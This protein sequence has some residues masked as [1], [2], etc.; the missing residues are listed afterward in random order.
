MKKKKDRRRL[1]YKSGANFERKVM[2]YYQDQGM[3]A[4]RSAGSHSPI[5]VVVINNKTKSVM[6]IQCKKKRMKLGN[7]FAEK[8]K[9]TKEALQNCKTRTYRIVPRIACLDDNNKLAIY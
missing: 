4:F 2:K 5:D 3:L 9:L 1:S 6:L 8:K 7:I